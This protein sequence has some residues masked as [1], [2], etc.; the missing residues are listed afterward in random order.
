MASV[1]F[2]YEPVSLDVY[3]ACFVEEQDIPNTH[4]K[5]RNNQIVNGVNVGNEA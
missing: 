5:S 1:G 3:K 2:Q 4:E